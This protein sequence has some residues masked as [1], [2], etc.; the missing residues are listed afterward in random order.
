MLPDHLFVSSCDGALHDTR[1]PNWHKLPP[2]RV[3]YDKGHR[4][5]RSV[6]DLKAALRHGPY[7]W[8]GG[9]PLYFLTSDGEVL[10]FAVVRAE[11]KLIA[12][13]IQDHDNSGWR[14]VGCDINYEDQ[15]LYCAHTGMPIE[16]AYGED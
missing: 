13:A 9:Y 4:S 7:A 8:P 14:V 15:D 11:F 5:I 1:V 2:L 10:S 12:R 16:A 3:N 6:A